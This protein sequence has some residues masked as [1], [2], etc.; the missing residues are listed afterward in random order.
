[1]RI[2]LAAILLA[3]ILSLPAFAAGPAADEHGAVARVIDGATF[4]LA[5]G[6]TVRLAAL[7]LPPPE[8][9][10]ALAEAARGTLAALVERREV[11]LAARGAGTDRYGRLVAHAIDADGRW[12]QAELVAKGLARVAIAADDRAPLGTL[13]AREAEAREAR[14]GLWALPQ[15][16]VLSADE[17][18][19]FLDTMQLVEGEVRGVA[20]N[21]GRV[22]LNFGA[23]WRS[24]FTVLVPAAARRRF[25]GHGLDLEALQGQM[26]R[27][28][29]WIEWYNGPLIEI[30]RPEQIEVIER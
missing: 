6:R 25:A 21:G 16:R 23:D 19:R 9:H 7:D 18:A 15:Y 27:V 28:R 30:A 3:A 10:R 12:I 24:D 2:G 29:G 17:A 22:F 8:R 13:L 5:D 4:A 1:M 20:R 26:V 14:R 11:G